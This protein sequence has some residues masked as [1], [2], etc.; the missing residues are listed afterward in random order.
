MKTHFLPFL[1]C[2]LVSLS[3]RAQISKTVTITTPGTLSTF[4]TNSEQASVTN[5]TISGNIDARDMAFVRDKLKVL[6]VINLS[7]AKISLYVGTAGT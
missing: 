2:L 4:F 3:L 1:F 7:A 6:S 5:L